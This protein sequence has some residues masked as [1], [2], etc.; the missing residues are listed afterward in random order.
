MCWYTHKDFTKSPICMPRDEENF[1]PNCP[2]EDGIPLKKD[3]NVNPCDTCESQEIWEC[4]SCCH[5]G[6][7]REPEK[8][9]T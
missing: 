9:S 5:N 6:Y 1:P 7:N 3:T 8:G 4:A 2:L